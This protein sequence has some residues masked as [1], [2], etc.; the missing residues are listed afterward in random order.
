MNSNESIEILQLEFYFTIVKNRQGG[1]NCYVITN[2]TENQLEKKRCII[3]VKNNDNSCFVIALSIA[4]ENLK[5]QQGIITSEKFKQFMKKSKRPK[6]IK[7][8]QKLYT[9]VGLEID[10]Q[11]NFSDCKKCSVSIR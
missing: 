4:L 10:T 6:W 9:L 5:K 8:F 3:Q 1:S 7:E 11:V 2:I